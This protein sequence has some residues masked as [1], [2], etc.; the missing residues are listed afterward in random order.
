MTES[1]IISCTQCNKPNRIPFQRLTEH[2]LC[3]SCKARLIHGIPFELTVDNFR[4]HANADMPL[5]VDF[6]ASWCGPCRQFSKV[7]EMVAAPFAERARFASLSTESQP[8]LAQS[9]AIRSLPTTVVFYKGQELARTS[10][11]LPPQQLH[12]WLNETLAATAFKE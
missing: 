10:G 12:A 1:V 4:A 9:Y 3:G 11:A 7:F 6:W 8:S 5:V 2:P